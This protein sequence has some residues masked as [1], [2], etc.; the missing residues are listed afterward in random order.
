VKIFLKK[1]LRSGALQFTVFVSVIIA[2][3]LAAV[4][5]LAYTHGFFM[6]Q[7]KAIVE[8]VQLADTGIAALKSETLITGDTIILPLKG[9]PEG[10]RLK[11]H[12]SRWGL[13][14]KAYAEATHRRKRFVKCAL[15]GSGITA[16][17]RPAIYLTETFTPLAIVGS[18][19]I[20][21]KA[22]LPQQ[23]IRPGNIAGNSYYGNQLLYGEVKKSE[24]NLPKLKYDYLRELDYYLTKFIPASDKDY[25][26]VAPGTKQINSF[27]NQVKGYY[28]PESIV[29]SEVA[30]YGNIIIRSDKKVIIR[31]ETD[32]R[33]II[34]AA[35]VIEIEEGFKGNLQAFADTTIKVGNGCLLYYPSA[36]ILIEKEKAMA[37]DLPNEFYNKIFIS[38]NSEIRGSVCYFAIPGQLPDYKV[39]IFSDAQ[40]IIHGEIYC[41]GNLEIK[42]NVDGSIY[43][44]QF[45]TNEA[46]SIFVNHLYNVKVSS[47]DLPEA[48]GGILFDK[49]TKNVIKWLY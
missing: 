26:S 2:L 41:E 24:T 15:M 35:P 36:L 46:G 1:K 44:H 16:N 25:I 5:L 28:S 6:K 20:R 7:S 22:F 45:L 31:K 30:L 13:F 4:I 27:Q 23:G 9:A 18:T 38:E 21:G 43:T 32:L 34:V 39:N 49:G 48:F 17:E 33:N 3:L 29:L 19:E 12:L 42:G 11:I 10:Q 14:E 8:N 37:P 40:S 47:E